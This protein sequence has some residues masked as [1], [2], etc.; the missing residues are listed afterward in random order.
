[1]DLSSQAE[2]AYQRILGSKEIN[3]N[4]LLDTVGFIVNHSM[5][6]DFDKFRSQCQ[7]EES[8]APVGA[9]RESYRISGH[10]VS[11]GTCVDSGLQIRSILG[12]L[13]LEEKYKFLDVS[14]VNG[15]S[16]DITVV[17]DKKSGEWAVINSKSP[18]KPYNLVPKN[19]LVELGSPYFKS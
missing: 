19:R 15:S 9:A 10:E 14:S 2:S 11:K 8:Y 4:E 13:G 12:S 3:L 17:F 5:E 6:Y 18:S 7:R 1:L 16:H